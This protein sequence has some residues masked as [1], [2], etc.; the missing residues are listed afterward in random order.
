M[1]SANLNELFL[2]RD[3]LI[4]LGKKKMPMKLAF[5]ISKLLKLIENEFKIFEEA[6]QKKMGELNIKV[7]EN[8]ILDRSDPKFQGFEKEINELVIN[9]NIEF[10]QDK[11]SIHKLESLE[12]EPIY[13]SQLNWLIED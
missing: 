10:K 7:N 13:L 5:D 6:R 8:G 11:I 1:I 2:S 4:E 3:A 9:T 12:I